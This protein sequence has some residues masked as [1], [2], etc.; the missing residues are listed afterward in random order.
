MLNKYTHI[1]YEIHEHSMD[2]DFILLVVRELMLSHASDIK[3]VI[4]SA[5]MQG[6]LIVNYLQ[7]HFTSVAG[8]YFVG[9]KQFGVETYFIDELHKIPCSQTF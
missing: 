9:V 1:I 6:S 8:P 3:L 5:T 2:A 4:M 7:Q